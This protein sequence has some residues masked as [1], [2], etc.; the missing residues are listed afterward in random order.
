MIS[1][2]TGAVLSRLLL[3]ASFACMSCG[4]KASPSTDAADPDSSGMEVVGEVG[5][6]GRSH[7]DGFQPDQ[8][9]IPYCS[10]DAQQIQEAYDALTV[11]QRIGQHIM[12]GILRSGAAP[13]G[14]SEAILRDFALGG[15]FVAGLTGTAQGDPVT[16]A[17]F[18][19]AAQQVSR[20]AT[21]LP[22]FVA[23]DQEG[24]VYTSVNGLTGGTDSIG[25]TAIGATGDEAVAFGQFDIMG[26]E[27]RA[28]GI[29]MNF[30]PLLDTHYE[31][32]NGNLNTRTFGPD[33]ALNTSLGVAAVLGM[34]QHLVLPVVKHFPGDGMTAGNTHHNDVVNDAP[35]AT[36]ETALLPPFKAAFL[37]GAEGVMMMP[38]RFAALDQDRPAI[39]SRKI[40]TGF[41]RGTLGYE[42]LIVTDDLDMAGAGIGLEAGQSRGIE[43][44]KA[45]A[46]V[47]LYVAIDAEEL[48]TL[49]SGVEQELESGGIDG[50]E[51]AQSTRRILAFKQRYCLDE[52]PRS[53]EE[54]APEVVGAQVGRT[55]DRN[56]SLEHARR[57]IVLLHD[58][59]VLPLAGKQVACIGPSAVLP[60]AASG[61]SWLLE[62]SL[63]Q[64]LADQMPGLVFQ[65][66]IAQ[67]G[68]GAA[69]SW[70]DQ[71][72]DQVDVLVVATFQAWFSPQ[73]Q[74]LLDAVLDGTDLPVVHVAQGVSFDA[75][76]TLDRASAVLALQGSLPVMFQAAADILLGSAEAGGTMRY[77]LE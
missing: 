56:A 47:L 44:L 50:E 69:V 16:S 59:G 76:L 41:L 53:P 26:R 60:D 72:R 66:F 18:L 74:E 10:E 8:V 29:T 67:G 62:K 61:W 32:G 14:P 38:A 51:F 45:G 4:G 31:I 68:E 24:G 54:V 22:L 28:L 70:L 27:L 17:R 77:E 37:A 25:P 52:L 30:G 39:T 33:V 35:L 40:I 64:S 73:Q 34:Q 3:F 23:T 20:E 36:L 57:A 43:A 13:A 42:G 11:R 46:D 65:D 6:D 58:D 9:E 63:C 7:P 21:G 1:R 71:N 49:V 15:V 19:A 75:M 12:T 2:I 5:A 55:A 48:E